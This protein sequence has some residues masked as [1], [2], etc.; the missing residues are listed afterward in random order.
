MAALLWL[1]RPISMIVKIVVDGAPVGKGRPRFSRKTGATYTPEKTAAY[2]CKVAWA[3]QQEMRG[4]ELL[5]GPLRLSISAFVE[6]PVSKSKKFRI[7]ALEGRELPTKKPDGDN[8]LKGVMD[9]LN[10]VVSV[11]DVQI[12]DFEF[13][14]RYCTK[15]RIEICI[16]NLRG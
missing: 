10:K 4:K 8:V 2:E 15:P 7:D 1:W 13:S 3:A 9:A 16:E 6:V 14:K 5:T 12:V 11:D